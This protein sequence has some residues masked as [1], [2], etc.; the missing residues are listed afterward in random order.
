MTKFAK[1]ALTTITV[2]ACASVGRDFS[3]AGDALV[4]VGAPEERAQDLCLVGAPVGDQD[5]LFV[6]EEQLPVEGPFAAEH[7]AGLRR[8]HV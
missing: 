8:A 4:V 7:A 6:V 5:E 3:R 1:W 2:F